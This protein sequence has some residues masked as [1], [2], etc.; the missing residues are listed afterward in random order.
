VD[1]VLLRKTN[2]PY[3][4]PT[5]TLQESDMKLN[6]DFYN[7]HVTE[8]ARDLLGKKLV[9]GDISGIITETEA[10]RGCD[11]LASHAARGIS[12]RCEIMFGPPGLSYV[13]F[14]YGMYHCF[15]IV[16]ESPGQASAVL[17]RSLK[18]KD[19][20]LNGP[21]KI[22]RHLNITKQQHG[23]NLINSDLLY[24]SSGINITDYQCTPRIGIKKATEKPWRFVIDPLDVAKL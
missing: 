5:S 6:Y 15:N 4:Q 12:P 16:T 2:P 17:I 23:I 8:V 21:G 9:Y 11:D 19:I 20:H 1:Y 7:R 18:L 10:Y 13:Y 24:V 14:I 22:C 3:I